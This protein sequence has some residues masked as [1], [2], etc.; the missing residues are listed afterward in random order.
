MPTNAVSA[1]TFYATSGSLAA[2]VPASFS[3]SGYSITLPDG[4]VVTGR[5]GYQ[6]YIRQNGTGIEFDGQIQAYI[7]LSPV[8]NWR[9][10]AAA[11]A[12][13][14]KITL[15]L[16]V[17]AYGGNGGFTTG[18]TDINNQNIYFNSLLLGT[19]YSVGTTSW[20]VTSVISQGCV[21]NAFMNKAGNGPGGGPTIT[22]ISLT[23]S[24]SSTS[25]SVVYLANV[26]AGDVAVS[27]INF[28]G[29]LLSNG[30]AYKGSQW[31]NTGNNISFANAITVGAA[32]VIGNLNLS[33]GLLSNGVP[34]TASKWTSTGNNIS[35]AN[36]ITVSTANIAG[37]GI[38]ATS[39]P[40]L[41]VGTGTYTVNI[42]P[43]VPGT[44]YN[45]LVATDDSLIMFT[46]TGSGTG[47][48]VIGPWSPQS[49]GI[50]LTS[51]G[52]NGVNTGAPA[53]PL[54]ING[55]SRSIG[56]INMAPFY[57]SYL[58]TF[59]LASNGVNNNNFVGSWG[60]PSGST[61]TSYNSGVS[62]SAPF[63]GVWVITS[64]INLSSSAGYNFWMSGGANMP[65]INGSGNGSCMSWT[66]FLAV[67]TNCNLQYYVNALPGTL[68][69]T[70]NWTLSHRT[71]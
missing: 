44:A 45:N 47:N 1:E 52:N 62:F 19:G 55:I 66:G 27:N 26:A 31:V 63:S 54:D 23:V 24:T 42:L 67:N 14:A 29:L 20:D 69:F 59:V 37:A 10:L 34:F 12:A 33:A 36:A 64:H 15:S 4:V 70:W 5:T 41:N 61:T 2:F 51:T 71:A 57:Q 68:N 9:R 16:T 21:F 49:Y 25:N 35:F 56:L 38:A 48:L 6:P 3:G 8:I 22:S 43:R 39:Q 40:T 32:N 53:Y 7:D 58:S 11:A 60:T 46:Q 65:Y 18:D 50:R 30:V 13:G 17:S 28:S